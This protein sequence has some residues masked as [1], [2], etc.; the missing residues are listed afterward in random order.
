MKFYN[1]FR[2]MLGDAVVAGQT[3]AAWMLSAQDRRDIV[4]GVTGSAPVD[5]EIYEAFGI[6]LLESSEMS[7]GEFKLRVKEPS[8]DA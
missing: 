3:P 8:N 6:P 1:E 2:S 4:M 5:G 7:V